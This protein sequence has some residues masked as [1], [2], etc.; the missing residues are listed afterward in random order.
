LL[1]SF[2]MCIYSKQFEIV[3]S[4]NVRSTSLHQTVIMVVFFWRKNENTYPKK[5]EH[6]CK[7]TELSL[8]LKEGIQLRDFGDQWTVYT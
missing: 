4:L 2:L 6:S 5:G 3:F 1:I 8:K 7:W